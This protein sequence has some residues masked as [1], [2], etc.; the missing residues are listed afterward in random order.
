MW[1]RHH[2]HVRGIHRVVTGTD[3]ERLYRD[4]CEIRSAVPF[5]ELAAAPSSLGPCIGT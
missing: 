5:D 1:L 4:R 3:D 2:F